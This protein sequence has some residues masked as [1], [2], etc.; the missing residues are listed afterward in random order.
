VVPKADIAKLPVICVGDIL[1]CDRIIS[2]YF[3]LEWQIGA[4]I[5]RNC[6]VVP[7][8]TISRLFQSKKN[9]EFSHFQESLGCGQGINLKRDYDGGDTKSKIRE[10]LKIISNKISFYKSKIRAI[11]SKNDIYGL[12]LRMMVVTNTETKT[13]S[14]LILDILPCEKNRSDQL[15][16][17]NFNKKNISRE[18]DPTKEGIV[19][20]G[21]NFTAMVPSTA[22]KQ[23]ILDYPSS[24][25]ALVQQ[26]QPG[27]GIYMSGIEIDTTAEQIHNKMNHQNNVE[28]THSTVT[29]LPPSHPRV[30]SI[31]KLFSQHL[32]TVIGSNPDGLFTD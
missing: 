18:I 8:H 6:M 24:R 11:E 7:R 3:G 14:N 25:A 4:D 1:F 9:I 21:D 17:I 30:L 19:T 12:V 27:S 31:T 32:K 16:K 22:R 23:I 5:D 13:L 20:V 10:K 28:C 15:S 2:K 26:I 29:V